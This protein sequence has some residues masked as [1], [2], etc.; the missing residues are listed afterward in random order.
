ME[1]IY[2]EPFINAVLNSFLIKNEL[3]INYK[4]NNQNMTKYNCEKCG[5][6]FNY[7]KHYTNHQ[8][9]N[10]ENSNCE[11]SNCENSNCENSNCENSN[12]EN[13]NCEKDINH[14][15]KTRDELIILCKDKGIKGYSGKKKE[16]I[17]MLINNNEK[18]EKQDTGKFRT[19][20]KDQFYTDENVAK[21]CIK[22]ILT[23]LPHTSEYLWVEPSAGNGAFL[24]NISSSYEKIGIDLEPK[25]NDII[26]QDYLTWYPPKDKDIIIFGNPPFGRQSS[27]AKSFISKSCEFA[28]VIAF[29]LPRSF[30]KP[31]MFSVFDLKFHLIYS[32]ELEK[33]SF[34]IN[35]A[36]YDVPCVFQ[37]WE[38]KNTYRIVEKKIKPEG[39]NYVKA[40]EKY[41]MVF[42]RVGGLAGKCYTNDGTDYSIQSHYFIK[43][44]E[45]IVYLLQDIIRKINNHTFPSNT[46]G[47]RSLSKSEANIVINEIYILLKYSS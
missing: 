2:S 39:F 1:K 41:D 45:N 18:S 47:P 27:L 8:N 12:C 29:I 30:T 24:N 16:D 4:N 43:F 42:R 36:K 13:S 34:V 26:K 11:N 44:D 22:D 33:D 7:K 17:L 14:S 31:S 46:L 40:T 19:N 20:M 25:T 35:G 28:K 21:S 10:C 3:K 38:K 23:L 5:L 6:K 37:I 9:S 32:K 15:S